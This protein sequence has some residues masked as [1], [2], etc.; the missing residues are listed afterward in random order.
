MIQTAERDGFESDSWYLVYCKPRQER[1]AKTNLE[2]QG[3]L[4]Y[5][6]LIRM[7][8]RRHGK[9]IL[10]IEPMFSRYLFIRLNKISQNWSPIRSTLGVVSLV[11]FG[12]EPSAVPAGLIDTIRGRD[13]AEGIQ[14]LPLEDFKQGEVVRIM[15]GPMRGYQGIFLARTAKDRVV[16]LLEIMGKFARVKVEDTQIETDK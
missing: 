9:R 8:R 13:D 11:R 4:T 3:Y 1:V 14:E 16:V 10:S 5:L 7:P 15:E 6:P 12:Q 2:R